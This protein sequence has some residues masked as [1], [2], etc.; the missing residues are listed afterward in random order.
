M[1]PNPILPPLIHH[2][3]RFGRVN[4][5]A[6]PFGHPLQGAVAMAVDRSLREQA[7]FTVDGTSFAVSANMSTHE[8]GNAG[9]TFMTATPIGD[10]RLPA[11]ALLYVGALACHFPSAPLAWRHVLRIYLREVASAPLLRCFCAPGFMPRT[12]PWLAG[13]AAANSDALTNDERENLIVLVRLTGMVL[14]Q[15]CERACEEAAMAGSLM[16]TDPK[17]FPELQGEEG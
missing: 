8:D 6:R 3:L 15:R 5:I 13:Y 4:P 1:I 16:A 7:L 12:M 10:G 9:F 14:L 11:E 17:R 2:D